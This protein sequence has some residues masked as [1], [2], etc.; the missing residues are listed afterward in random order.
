[1][2]KTTKCTFGELYEA[3]QKKASYIKSLGHNY[4]EI[5]ESDWKTKT[6]ELNKIW[7]SL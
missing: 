4:I 1:M 2:N 7:N 5:W 3:T 6:K